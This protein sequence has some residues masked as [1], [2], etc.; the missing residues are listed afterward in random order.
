[1]IKFVMAHCLADNSESID[2]SKVLG[3]M[4]DAFKGDEKEVTL[5]DIN[6]INDETLQKFIQNGQIDCFVFTPDTVV[7]SVGKSIVSSVLSNRTVTDNSTVINI[8]SGQD[9]QILGSQLK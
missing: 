9:E 4:S 5:L 6:N 3:C 7:S 2:K 8:Y 1:M